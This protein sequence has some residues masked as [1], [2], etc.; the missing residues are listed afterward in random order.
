MKSKMK[1]N[2]SLL[3]LLVALAMVPVMGAEAGNSAPL[4]YNYLSPVI[5]GTGMPAGYGVGTC[6]SMTDTFP[7]HFNLSNMPGYTSPGPVSIV[8][9]VELG[10][11]SYSAYK[12]FSQ[13]MKDNKL[14]WSPFDVSAGKGVDKINVSGPGAAVVMS[15]VVN[16]NDT[17]G[18]DNQRMERLLKL[19]DM[20]YGGWAPPYQWG[21][22]LMNNGRHDFQPDGWTA[23]KIDH[24]GLNF[25]VDLPK[26][27]I[28]KMEIQITNGKGAIGGPDCDGLRPLVFRWTR[29][30]DSNMMDFT[31]MPTRVSAGNSINTSA[32]LCNNFRV[33]AGGEYNFDIKSPANIATLTGLTPYTSPSFHLQAGVDPLIQGADLWDYGFAAYTGNAAVTPF[34][35]KYAKSADNNNP[36]TA[37][38]R[39]LSMFDGT[40]ISYPDGDRTGPTKELKDDFTAPRNYLPNTP[41]V[42]L[43]SIM[44]PIYGGASF[45]LLNTDSISVNVLG[46]GTGTSVEDMKV[47][48]SGEPMVFFPQQVNGRTIPAT[49]VRDA[50]Q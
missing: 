26:R 28:K 6:H 31:R 19:D 24:A 27:D 3:S 37:A 13:L 40:L 49:V 12:T 30:A 45:N 23:F 25:T 35:M 18:T 15:N 47:V 1:S 34:R 46:Q 36:I 41:A 16:A 43:K 4:S 33:G 7:I 42:S 9:R 2:L 20:K 39:A 21:F 44:S 22:K 11:Q 50:C 10:G 38:Q 32:L 48:V 14:P 5:R 8:F 29:R 17:S